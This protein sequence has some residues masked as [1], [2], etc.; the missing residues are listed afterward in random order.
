M[1]EMRGTVPQPDGSRH[2]DPIEE[3]A[4]EPPGFATYVAQFQPLADNDCPGPDAC[5]KQSDH[6]DLHDDVGLQKQ[7]NR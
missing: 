5:E 2:A 4:L 1:L 6:D 7:G 3:I